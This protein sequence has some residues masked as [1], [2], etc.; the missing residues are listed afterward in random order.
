MSKT[1]L[2]KIIEAYFTGNV[3]DFPINEENR[4]LAVGTLRKI[5]DILEKGG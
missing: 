4:G 1:M 5:A 3:K 2:Q